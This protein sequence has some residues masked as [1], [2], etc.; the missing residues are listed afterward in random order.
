MAPL[1]CLGLDDLTAGRLVLLAGGTIYILAVFGLVCRSHG[2]D[3]HRNRMISVAVMTVAVLQAAMWAARLLDPD[4]LAD[5]LLFCYFYVVL[6]PLLCRRPLRA[7]FGGA[8]A[9]MASLGKAYM[10][11]FTLVHLAAT[12]LMRWRISRRSGQAAGP[13]LQCWGTTWVLCLVAQALIAGPWVA[14]L[15]SHY[16]KLTLST[17]G[18]ANHAN[19]GPATFGNDPLWNP[20]LV[21]DYIADPH[22]G[23]DWSP[24]QDSEHFLHQLKVIAFHLNICVGYVP[25]WSCSAGFSRWPEEASGV[26]LRGRP[27][28]A[29]PFQAC[30]GASSRCRSTSAGTA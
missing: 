5:G 14:V 7:L 30:G 3:Q 15:T 24:L 26:A 12:L 6:D 18:P 22:F 27:V 1:I 21:A 13:A 20:G 4:L 16:G 2:T 19:M 10:L 17:A 29:R 8:A 11:P 25:P 23:P 9:G 28:T